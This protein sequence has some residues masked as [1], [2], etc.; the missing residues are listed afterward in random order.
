MQ[1]QKLQQE[2]WNQEIKNSNL[3]RVWYVDKGSEWHFYFGKTLGKYTF[4][5]ITPWFQFG[6]AW[7]GQKT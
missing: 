4:N 7:D 3:K 6:Y 1:D 2:E 5:F